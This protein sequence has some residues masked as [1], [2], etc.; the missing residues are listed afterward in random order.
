MEFFKA[1]EK[2]LG[3]MRLLLK[4]MTMEIGRKGK[5][6]WK[7]NPPTLGDKSIGQQ[8]WIRFYLSSYY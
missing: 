5:V 3:N 4:I 8:T 6:F 7:S 2:G 1:T